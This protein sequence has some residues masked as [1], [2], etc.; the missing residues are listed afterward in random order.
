MD[1]GCE[2]RSDENAE[3]HTSQAVRIYTEHL[4]DQV[5]GR[6]RTDVAETFLIQVKSSQVYTAPSTI[7]VLGTWH[8]GSNCTALATSHYGQAWLIR[9][10]FRADSSRIGLRDP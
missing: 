10:S 2:D 3:A 8:L 5:R 7:T 6:L 1:A 9:T 4:D